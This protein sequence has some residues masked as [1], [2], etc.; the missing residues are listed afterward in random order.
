M[1]PDGFSNIANSSSVYII[2]EECN[3][4]RRASTYNYKSL[5]WAEKQCKYLQKENT[6]KIITYRVIEYKP[7]EE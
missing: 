2:V 3:N 4:K 6:N 1:T 5:K 7:I